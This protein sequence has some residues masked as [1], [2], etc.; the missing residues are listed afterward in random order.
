MG[1]NTLIRSL[2]DLG[3]ASWFGGSRMGALGVNG[4]T[5]DISDPTERAQVAA[6]GWA[7][8]SPVAAASIGAHLVGGLGLVVA[9]RDRVEKES[10]VG[11]NTAVKTALTVAAMASTAYSGFLGA[12][13]TKE[14]NQPSEGAPSPT[15]A[16]APRPPG[17][18]SSC[19]SC[20]G[21]AGPDRRDHRPRGA[22][23]RAAA[24][25]PYDRGTRAQGRHRT[26]RQG[27]LTGAGPQPARPGGIGVDLS[28]AP[29][30]TTVA[31]LGAI[32]ARESAAPRAVRA[33]LR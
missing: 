28:P 32:L 14:P 26:A 7:R 6:S 1:D 24:G 27:R 8:W 15:R 25:R 23:G 12:Q 9:N 4:A 16:P 10:G 3:A 30:M 17:S 22:A 11:A 33:T 5:K 20:S 2:H 13:L 19:A 31:E 18:S 21:D 29:L